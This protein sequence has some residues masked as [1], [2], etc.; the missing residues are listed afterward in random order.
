MAP[1]EFIT[2]RTPANPWDT[3]ASLRCRVRA[4]LMGVFLDQR[5]SL[6][7]LR[8]QF[9]VLVRMIHRYYATV[10]LL[11]DVRAGHTAICLPRRPVVEPTTG[12]SEVSRFSCEEFLDVLGVY[13][14]AGPVRNSRY[15]SWPC[16]RPL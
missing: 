8:R 3:R 4:G 7:T 12:A 15:R 11:E 14:Y 10:R 9:P 6:L 2:L 1:N 5:P 13:D 16:C